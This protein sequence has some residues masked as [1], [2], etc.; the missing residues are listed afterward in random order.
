M[1]DI[2]M[3]KRIAGML[4]KR[5]PEAA[6]DEVDD[7]RA[8]RGRR[9]GIASVLRAVVVGMVAGCHSLLELEQLTAQMAPRMRRLLKLT[10]RLPDTTARDLLCRLSPLAL[11]QALHRLIRHA[12]R[13]KA[14]APETLPF[15]MVAMDGKSTA[16]SSWAGDYAQYQPH[17]EGRGAHGVLRTVTS[18][19]V[20]TRARPCIDAYP[21]PA[22]TNEMGVFEAAFRALI[23]AYPR[24]SQLFQL[25]S[26]DAGA[27]SLAN[28]SL[29]VDAGYDYLF[30]LKGAQPSLRAEAERILAH[31]DQADAFT[32]DVTGN[33]S[34]M[35]RVF[36]SENLEGF[37]DWSH[38]QTFIRVD[39]ETRDHSGRCLAY[40]T[41]YF[42]CSF[43]PERLTPSQWLH[44]VRAHWGVENNC[45]HTLDVA[46]REDERPWIES[47]PDGALALMLLRR[48]AYSALTLFRA[49]TQRAEQRRNTPWRELMHAVYLALVVGLSVP[50]PDLR[51]P[52]ALAFP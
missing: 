23:R 49:V 28:A 34:V 22:A 26:Y 51:H 30:S 19:L 32:E 50:E 48:I 6:L 40:E 10:G 37:L 2:R 5:L 47:D 25:V 17:G 18:A 11:R 31:R 52:G 9:R 1:N 20:S 38:L 39:S 21:I 4:A 41:R 43:A 24:S 45:H 8:R 42:L 36:V 44:A 27:C 7:P 14:L 13:R 33:T 16:L 46:F 3:T 35:R 12:H 15:G 29:V